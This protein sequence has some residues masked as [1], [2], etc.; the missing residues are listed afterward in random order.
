LASQLAK[1]HDIKIALRASPYG[2]TTAIVLIPVGLVVPEGSYEHDPSAGTVDQ[3]AIQLTGRHAARDDEKDT[4]VSGLFAPAFGD[5]AKNGRSVAEP[6]PSFREDPGSLAYLEE[7]GSLAFPEDPESLGYPGAP[8]SPGYPEVPGSLTYAEES[9]SLAYPEEAEDWSAAR[10]VAPKPGPVGS[11]DLVEGELPRRVR[12]ASL[13]PQ[14]RDSSGH[15]DTHTDSDS[16]DA[17]S[18]EEARATVSAIQQGWQRGR[19]LFDPSDKG[20]VTGT[21]PS[22]DDGMQQNDD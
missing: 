8:G 14:L 4:S 10:R 22:G 21:A 11:D 2:G 13:A 5:P 9:G 17:R 3:Q 20:T 18:P 19:S 12:Q 15:I 1:R 6:G 7:P 16:A